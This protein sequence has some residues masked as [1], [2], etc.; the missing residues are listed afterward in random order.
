MFSTLKNK[1][2]LKLDV[3]ILVFSII[4]F[5]SGAVNI[6]YIVELGGGVYEVNLVTTIPTIIGL[7]LLVPFGMLSDR[8]GRKPMLLYPMPLQLVTFIIYAFASNPNHLIIASI[9]SGLSGNEFMPVLLA[10]VGDVAERKQDALGLFFFMSSIGIFLG[11]TIGSLILLIPGMTIRNLYQILTATQFFF[12]IYLIVAI[13]E[14][15]TKKGKN[16]K[17]FSYRFS[18]SSLLHQRRFQGLITALFMYFFYESIILTYLPMLCVNLNFTAAQ[19][20]SISSFRNLAIMLMRFAIPLILLKVPSI[21]L[22]SL[23]L[24]LG[25]ASGIAPVFMNNYA[26]ST[27]IMFT[28]G[29]SYG[30]VF[31]LASIF[32]A[33]WSTSENRGVANSL[34]TLTRGVSFMVR[35]ATTPIANTMGFDVLFILSG[36]TSFLSLLPIVALRRQMK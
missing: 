6:P 24:L 34:V 8:F 1:T 20:S 11:P 18:F 32:T 31:T 33:E 26:V 30:I 12:M 7:V 5:M 14:T 4:G 23:G 21:Q 15:K 36:L 3:T 22:F 16:D 17:A 19:I 2:L 10:M 28:S 27:I 35:M 13:K 25:G 29:L 9:L